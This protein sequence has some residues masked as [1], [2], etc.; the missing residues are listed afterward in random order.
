M[1]VKV[2]YI[3]INVTT[4]LHMIKEIEPVSTQTLPKHSTALSGVLN[5]MCATNGV[6]RFCTNSMLK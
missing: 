1:A 2:L 4:L 6:K 5:I 3:M